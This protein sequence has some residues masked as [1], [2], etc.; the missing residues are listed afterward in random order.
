MNESPGKTGLIIFLAIIIIA[1]GAKIKTKNETIQELEAD[2]SNLSY[3][4]RIKEDELQENQDMLEQAN[5]NI[6]DARY[7]AWESYDEMGE[8]LDNLET[9]E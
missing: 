2:N 1:M 4:L 6:E 9:V 8:A 3:D 7:Y 5:S